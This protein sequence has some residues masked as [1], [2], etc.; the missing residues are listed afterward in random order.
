MLE[1]FV[2]AVLEKRKGGGGSGGRKKSNDSKE[3][4]GRFACWIVVM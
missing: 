1:G 3:E 4:E 2:G